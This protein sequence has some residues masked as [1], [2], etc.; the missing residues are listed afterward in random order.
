MTQYTTTILSFSTLLSTDC[1][2]P[3]KMVGL[4]WFNTIRLSVQQHSAWIGFL[5]KYVFSFAGFVHV[6]PLKKKK[7]T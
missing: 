5:G 6:G 4:A 7:K 1:E 2:F 3:Q